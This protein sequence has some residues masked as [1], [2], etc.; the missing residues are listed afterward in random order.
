MVTTR[1]SS[2]MPEQPDTG[3]ST[4][5]LA[6]SSKRKTQDAEDHTSAKKKR[7][8]DN[9]KPEATTAKTKTATRIRFGSEEVQPPAPVPD[10]VPVVADSEADDGDESLEEED[11]DDEAPEDISTSVAQKGA[12][13]DVLAAEKAIQQYV[14]HKI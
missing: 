2:Y 6:R 14:C 7:K 4:S 11:S 13:A 5:T 9:D 8:V 3:S 10:T 1:H 12:E